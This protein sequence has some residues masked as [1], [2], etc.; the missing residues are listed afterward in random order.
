VF[1][2]ESLAVAAAAV[3]ERASPRAAAVPAA[4][5]AVPGISAAAATPAAAAESK[6]LGLFADE[7]LASGVPAAWSET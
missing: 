7:V 6:P 2:A 5:T 1:P 3:P 4:A